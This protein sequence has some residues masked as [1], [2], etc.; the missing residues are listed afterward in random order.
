[1]ADAARRQQ[2]EYTL[3]AAIAN[4]QGELGQQTGL[5]QLYGGVYGG[6]LG[7]LGGILTAG[8]DDKPWWLGG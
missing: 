5:A 3:E 8:G 6:L 4:L 2:G 1:M 7:G